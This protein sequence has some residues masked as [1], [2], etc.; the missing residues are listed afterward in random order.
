MRYEEIHGDLFDADCDFLVHGCNAQGV[1]RSGVAKV[2]RALYPHAF[3][4]YHQFCL[5]VEEPIQRLGKI[6]V[7]DAKHHRT[8]KPFK[9]VNAITQLNYGKDGKRYVSYGAIESCLL[10]L[11]P[12]L[13]EN[14]K[15][16][17]DGS[18]ETIPNS[19]IAMPKIGAGLGGGDWEVIREIVLKNLECDVKVY[20]I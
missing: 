10:Y 14:S 12:F 6:V 9:I 17:L 8:G 19:V 18:F 5:M 4:A 20:W 2:L 11:K 13:T 16:R 15:T 3:E 1:M 7:V